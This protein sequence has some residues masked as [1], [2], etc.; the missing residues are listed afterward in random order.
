M[1]R[2]RYCGC[3]APVST[4]TTPTPKV[5]GTSQKGTRTFAVREDT[6]MESQQ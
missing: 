2:I 1:K 4:H 6:V 3:V 5:Q